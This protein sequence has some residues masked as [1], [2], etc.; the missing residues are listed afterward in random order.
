MASLA[1]S[2]NRVSEQPAISV[3]V[4]S[5]NQAAFIESALR[6]LIDQRYAP[7]EI[8]VIDGGSTDGTV[9]VLQRLAV[10]LS[11]WHS[12]P[13]A[14]P[15][16]AANDGL[17]RATGEILGVLNADDF[18]LP[19]ALPR[20][21]QTFGTRPDV[22]VVSGHGYFAASDGQ[23]GAPVYSDRWNARRFRY[24]A[25]VLVQP[26]TFFRQRAFARAGGFRQ[27]GRVCWDME[28]WADMARS[29]A[30]FMTIDSHLAAF[31]LHPASITGRDDLQARRR[32]DARAVAAEFSG[33]ADTAV[34]RVLYYLHRAAKFI[35]HPLRTLRQ[36]HFVFA[37]LKRWS[38]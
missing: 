7:L 34:D 24:G 18:L 37:I 28:L 20:I 17:A 33:G 27:S 5:L 25:C 30:R 13:D 12:V 19:G 21:A 15:A 22:D 36:R 32:A 29:G 16:A 2:V 8:I 10:H 23:L 3:V 35:R 38:V 4:P 31:R 6:S 9:D 26:A 11:Y 14:G 1:A